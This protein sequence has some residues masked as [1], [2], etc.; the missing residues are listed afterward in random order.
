MTLPHDAFPTSVW[1]YAITQKSLLFD[2]KDLWIS[3]SYL[4]IDRQGRPAGR[5]RWPNRVGGAT[6]KRYQIV[7]EALS[8][9]EPIGQIARRHQVSEGLIYRWRDKFHEGGKAA[10][11]FEGRSGLGGEKATLERQVEELQKLIGEQAVEIRFLKRL[12]RS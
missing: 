7:K 2:L 8:Q 4:A 11:A 3:E 1:H 9:K 12:S 5:I 6:E 10:L